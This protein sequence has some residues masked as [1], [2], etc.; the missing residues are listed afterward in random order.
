MERVGRHLK[1]RL[2]LLLPLA[3]LLAALIGWASEPVALDQLRL[4]VFDE[5][6]RLKPRS[7]EAVPVRI[8]DIDDESLARLGQWPWP[9]T[10]VA[11]LVDRLGELGA[12]AIAFDIVFAEPDRTSP[13]HALEDLKGLKPDD[14]LVARLAALP[15]HDVLL[16]EA[17]K[18]ARAVT[19]FVMT[20][21]KGALVPKAKAS[22]ANAGDDPRPWVPN[23]GGA[24][25][26]LGVL[27]DAAA[28][29]GSTND[30]LGIDGVT[31]RVPL[32]VELGNRLYPALAA[33]ALRVAQGGRTYIVKSTGASGVMSFGEHAG[34]NSIKIGALIV[35]T[36]ARGTVWI[37]FTPHVP[38]RFVPAWQVLDQ[39]VD[40]ELIK[41]S[42]V[43][44]GT[45]AAGLKEFHATPLDP[46][47]AGVEIHAELAE[48]ML[49]GDSLKRPEWARGVELVY[50]L[51]TGIALLLLL[52]R[53]GARWTA[54]LG[55][56]AAGSAVGGSW[57][58]Y[59]TQNLLIDPVFPSVVALLVYLSSSAVLFLRT[60]TERRRVR[61]AFGRY[62]AP[63][64]VEQLSRHPERLVLGGEMREM[65]LMFSD[66]RGF[67]GIAERF[68]AQGLTS[69]INRF[70][71]P[72]T[73][74]ILA[75][76]GTIDKYMGDAIM[77]FWNAPLDDAAHAEHACRA[78][79][80]MRA[81]LV[82]L[83]ETWRREAAAEGKSFTDVRT[84]I[85]L[86]TGT[87]CVGNLGSDQRFDY[88]CLGDDVNLASRLEGQSTTYG[89]DI[90]VGE[91]TAAEAK[92]LAFL[93]LDLV[94]VKGKARPAHIF[95]LLGDETVEATSAFA[96]LKADH[97][98]MLAA[99]RGRRWAE[100]LE[101]LEACR[102][103]A[104]ETLQAF[105][106]LYEERIAGFR[107]DP[108][109]A[110]WDGAFVALTK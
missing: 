94:R 104:P 54:L 25:V 85:G 3:I 61:S 98:A 96:A 72:M 70:L 76:R 16:G 30:I 66:I 101:R 40:P 34:I 45:S 64:V 14:P 37:H 65:T 24:I 23:F 44:V 46:D 39:S 50:M 51:V 110:D 88:S 75:A 109:P 35:P 63:A 89:V 56:G 81:E 93:E 58:A 38:E 84:G 27:E 1:N 74:V 86:N 43:F 47:A 17:L 26:N 13:A 90:V 49:L 2:H 5:F 82:R 6:M 71:T 8:V 59:A 97:D 15:D 20:H 105:Y 102:A 73:D 52:P 22:F 55:L 91:K 78:A 12:A 32:L 11:K 100:A 69:F 62:L 42:I 7:Y 21:K 80:T 18:R 68:D 57:Y 28:G 87:C 83:N 79:L 10:L 36:D 92:G 95:A 103:Q 19:G 31:R 77:A 41:G 99:Y 60:E 4:F 107:A 108:P 9:R 67:T 33:E 106:T 53:V 48:Q 29:N